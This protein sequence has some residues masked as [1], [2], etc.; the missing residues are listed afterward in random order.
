M[1]PRSAAIDLIKSLPQHS[2]Y[3]DIQYHLY[4]MEKVE[5]GLESIKE[6]KYVSQS[7]AE[8]K[9]AQWT[10]SSGRRQR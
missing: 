7:I 1:K 8:K 2:T 5:K 9:V 6:G 10:K 3:E 4:V